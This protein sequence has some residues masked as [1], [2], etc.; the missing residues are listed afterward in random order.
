[1]KTEVLWHNDPKR[2]FLQDLKSFVASIDCYA[3]AF[4]LDK[5]DE[6]KYVQI[7]NGGYEILSKQK[8]EAFKCPVCENAVFE[9]MKGE[10][11]GKPA[12]GLCCLNCESYGVVFPDGM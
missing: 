8:A 4:D 5:A 10:F 7:K 2:D 9:V 3:V 6:K 1:M 11:Q 12:L